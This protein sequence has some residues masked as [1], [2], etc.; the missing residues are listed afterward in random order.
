MARRRH[1]LVL[2]LAVNSGAT[3][4]L[5]VLALGGAFTSVMTGNMVLTGLGAATSDW[6]LVVLAVTAIVCFSVGCAVG[7]RVAGT[8]A[9]EDTVWPRAICWAL[10][11]QLALTICFAFGWWL[12][13]ADPSEAAQLVM[14]AVNAACL[15]IQSS[16]VQR[17]GQPGLS[18]TYLTGTLTT[19]VVRLAT[20]HRLTAV[21][22]SLQILVALVG[23]AALGAAL[24][25]AVPM[26]APLPQLVSLAVVLTV[27][28]AGFR[29]P[30]PATVATS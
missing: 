7:V 2:V 10:L 26:A 9:A 14:L 8:P 21:S 24:T 29:D 23:G 11:V 30:S 5:G 3:D 15:G 1:H 22:S 16:A 19:L 4:A 27:G 20:G 12:A 17:L 6:A 18:T 28:L 25:V 13:Q